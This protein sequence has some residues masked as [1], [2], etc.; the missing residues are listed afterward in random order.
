MSRPEGDIVIGSG[1]AGYAAARA[2][3]DRGR[4]VTIVDAGGKLEPENDALRRALAATE[5]QDWPVDVLNDFRARQRAITDSIGRFGSRF[6]LRSRDAVVHPPEPGVVLQ[7]SHALGGLS[8]VWGSAVLPWSPDDLMEWPVP[9]AELRP[10]YRAVAELMPIA[11][12][13]AS[14]DDV[15]DAGDLPFAKP[16]P[17]TRQSRRLVERLAAVGRHH[18]DGEYW[19]GPARQAVGNE[20]RA[21][22]L[23]LYGC[24]YG[25]IFTTRHPVQNLLQAG[26]IAYEKAEVV[27]I[28][29]TDGGV[30]LHLADGR[31]PISGARVFVAAGVLE[32]AR[33]MFESD[34]ESA[35]R[36]A[37]LKDSRHFFTPFLQRWPA[38]KTGA[39]PHHTLALAF[40]EFRDPSVSPR[41]VH[42]QLYGWN[43][44]YQQEMAQKYG[45]GISALNPIFG[46]V[47]QRLIVAQ[48]FLHSDHCARIALR[49]APGDV[50]RRLSVEVLPAPGYDRVAGLARKRL[51]AWLRRAGLYGIGMAGHVGQPGSSFHTGGTFPMARAP[52]AGETDTLGRPGGAGHIHLV[53]ASVVPT[54]PASTIT[55]SVMANAHRIASSV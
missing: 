32:T 22:G 54:V 46:A 41:L 55:F 37:I 2:L 17:T 36:G 45:H 11:G 3:L 52:G 42:N 48:T 4:A 39:G 12:C 10:H 24:P 34:A 27:S 33:L 51:M 5:P 40:V 15:L 6:A 53:D 35:R 19:A 9:A 16:L 30:V 43:D 23:C 25:Q 1:P 20:C 28:R 14:Y 8:N 49:P 31:P 50:A 29:E 7:S 18:G 47:S 44:L 38:G 21:C 26:R 13:A